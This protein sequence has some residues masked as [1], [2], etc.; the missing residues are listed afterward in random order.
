MIVQVHVHVHVPCVVDS[1]V[2]SLFP[3]D[4]L[5]RQLL[6]LTGEYGIVLTCVGVDTDQKRLMQYRPFVG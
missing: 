5:K 4:E 3:A 6:Q 1:Y 2:V